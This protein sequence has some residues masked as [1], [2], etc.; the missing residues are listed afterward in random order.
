[1]RRPA[2]LVI[3]PVIATAILSGFINQL[4]FVGS[5]V[6]WLG[7]GLTC[8][9]SLILAVV[10]ADVVALPFAVLAGAVMLSPCALP[11]SFGVLL[12]A[13]GFAVARGIGGRDAGAA[14]LAGLTAAAVAAIWSLYAVGVW[15]V[16]S[17][18][19]E[20][21]RVDAVNRLA[22]E[23]WLSFGFTR[24]VAPLGHANHT[25]GLGVLLLPVFVGLA[26]ASRRAA[27]IVWSVSALLALVLIVAGGSRAALLAPAVA[28]AAAILLA[29]V[30]K[31]TARRKACLIAAGL[32]A[33]VA[34]IA[35]HRPFREWVTNPAS[36]TASDLIRR[37]YAEGCVA[38]LRDRPATGVG[39]GAIP[40]LYPRYAPDHADTLNCYHAHSTPFQWLAEFGVLGGVLFAFIVLGSLLALRAAVSREILSPAEC[41]LACAATAYAAFAVFDY[42]T[43]IPA[44]GIVWGVVL[45]TLRPGV[46]GLPKRISRIVAPMTRLLF[47]AAAA[48]ALWVV[49]S[50][51]SARRE[52]FLASHATGVAAAD[53]VF[54][55]AE[56]APADAGVRGL[57]AAEAERLATETGDARYFAIADRAWTDAA[58]LCP[59]VPYMLLR[60]AMSRMRTNAGEALPVFKEVLSRDPKSR[61]AVSALAMIYASRGDVASAET[62][63]ALG[64]FASPQNLDSPRLAGLPGVSRE[65]VLK[66]FEALRKRYA[67]K[68]PDDAFANRALAANAA[69]FARIGAAHGMPSAIVPAKVSQGW[70]ARFRRALAGPDPSAM[71][72]LRAAVFLTQDVEIDDAR[73]AVLLRA[74]RTGDMSDRP[75]RLVATPES[76]LWYGA[77]FGVGDVPL[78][79]PYA[80]SEDLVAV[81]FHDHLSPEIR[82]DRRFLREEWAKLP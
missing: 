42:Q 60:R 7:Y 82:A 51:T 19:P 58:R 22:G 66:R 61:F 73:A 15:V 16:V 70:E 11:Y 64:L 45:G 63:L 71:S 52:L 12:F 31:L 77:Y 74:Y 69:S 38:M 40:T 75:S 59:E 26:V 50:G 24:M 25:S 1:M 46:S 4:I 33:L 65:S 13:S 37:D 80:E 8:V 44:L 14:R 20:A 54:R 2:A 28:V 30:A 39:A 76:T 23:P 53:H 43:N 17:L 47:G 9:V 36:K 81:L 29:P 21:T 6:G 68:Y 5:Y 62:A 3:L 79:S 57:A 18:V 72:A 41:G 27:R 56:S 67:E 49:V 78:S 48:A 35:V 34:L 55:A 10:Y 32:V